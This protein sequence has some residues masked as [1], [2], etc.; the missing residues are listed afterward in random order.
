MMTR[1][2]NEIVQMEG[3]KLMKMKVSK[4]RCNMTKSII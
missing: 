1:E 3:I 4:A 2:M